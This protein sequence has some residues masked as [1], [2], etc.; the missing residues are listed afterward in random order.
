MPGNLY[1]GEILRVGRFFFIHKTGGIFES[2]SPL[3]GWNI[4]L[5]VIWITVIRWQNTYLR[6]GEF[7]RITP[8]STAWNRKMR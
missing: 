6:L 8:L 1:I 7:G 4:L 5:Q 3:S 2:F